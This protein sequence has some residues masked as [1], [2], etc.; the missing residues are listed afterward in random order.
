MNRKPVSFAVI[1]LTLFGMT[2]LFGCSAGKEGDSAEPGSPPGKAA[3]QTDSGVAKQSGRG[4]GQPDLAAGI[5]TGTEVGQMAPDFTLTGIDGK[6]VTLSSF[7]GRPVMLN[8]WATW[9]PPCKQE[10]PVIQ[11]FFAGR[12]REMQVLAVNLMVREKSPERV[13]E[14][15]KANGYTFPVLLDEKNDVAKQ[16][17]IRYIPTTYF[18][19]QRGII[20][21]L[22][23]G[24][25]TAEMLDQYLDRVN[26]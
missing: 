6:K 22:H 12:G 26:K 16:Y 24:P 15:L 18:I 20:R 9:C 14:F 1:C 25:L 2:L 8:F 5:P 17:L 7:R 10:M 11:K 23:T 21:G 19:D 13:K 4:S 3:E